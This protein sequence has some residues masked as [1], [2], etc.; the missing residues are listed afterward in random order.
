M[1]FIDRADGPALGGPKN[2][3]G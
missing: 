1:S 3:R 2:Y